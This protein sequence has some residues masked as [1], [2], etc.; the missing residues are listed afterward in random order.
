MRRCFT[1]V[2]FR[3]ACVEATVSQYE[4]NDDKQN[5]DRRSVFEYANWKEKDY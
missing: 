1:A 5:E 4:D 2:F 3:G